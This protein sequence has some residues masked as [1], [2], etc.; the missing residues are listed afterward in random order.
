MPPAAAGPSVALSSAILSS[1]IGEHQRMFA[2]LEEHAQ[3]LA[4]IAA[5]MVETLRTGGKILFCGNGGSAADA[6]H[7]AAELVGRFRQPRRG[8]AA[9]A[10]TTDSSVVT[11]IANDFG[12]SE[13][14]RRQVEALGAPGDMLIGLSTSG[15]SENV[16]A[17]MAEARRMGLYGVALVGGKGG[18]LAE[19]ADM[20]LCVASC[21][22]ARVQEAHLFCGHVLCELVECAMIEAHWMTRVMEEQQAGLPFEFP[23]ADLPI[24]SAVPAG[25]SSLLDARRKRH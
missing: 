1:A 14:F 4:A 21:S 8:L 9:L 18:R 25:N 6:Q 23:I 12:F 5:R 16:C 2:D 10:L 3:V 22:T 7:L 24:A 17:A 20:V 13:V 11:S 19:L 15:E